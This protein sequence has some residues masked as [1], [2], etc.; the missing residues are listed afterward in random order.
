MSP[1][2]PCPSSLSTRRPC[3]RRC[4]KS[5]SSAW[6]GSRS[7][8]I[9]KGERERNSLL[10]RP[11][12][13]LVPKTA[14]LR[15]G[16]PVGE[17]HTPPT[18]GHRY[19]D[20][21]PLLI[22]EGSAGNFPWISFSGARNRTWPRPRGSSCLLGTTYKNPSFSPYERWRRP[23][24]PTGCRLVSRRTSP[25]RPAV[26]LQGRPGSQSC[27]RPRIRTRTEGCRGTVRYRNRR[28]TRQLGRN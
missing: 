7:R 8:K 3:R 9:Q 18:P 21:N 4:R 26:Q 19:T 20:A 22:L 11:P 10:S 16:S 12:G 17:R 27:S 13:C 28:D 1:C 23:E 6:S 24:F 25:S 5:S 14:F 15:S 2:R